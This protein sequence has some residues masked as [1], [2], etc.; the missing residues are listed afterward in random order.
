MIRRLQPS[1]Y[2]CVDLAILQI[3]FNRLNRI[4]EGLASLAMREF[5]GP[6]L[7]GSAQNNMHM[8]PAQEM[9]G[10]RFLTDIIS[11]QLGP[12]RTASHHKY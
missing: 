2:R 3:P 4:Y 12:N 6:K 7:N 8:I 5:K 9:S 11:R 1:E 10:D